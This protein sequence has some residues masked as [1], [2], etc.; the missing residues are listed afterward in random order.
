MDEPVIG[1]KLVSCTWRPLQMIMC[2]HVPNSLHMSKKVSIDVYICCCSITFQRHCGGNLI[3]YIRRHGY[4]FV[5]VVCFCA[6][7]VQG[8]HL[9]ES[10]WMSTMAK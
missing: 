2:K 9:L 10:L 3:E 7:T 4:Y 8:Q 6:A 1:W 5:T